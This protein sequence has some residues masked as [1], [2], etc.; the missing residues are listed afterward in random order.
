MDEIIITDELGGEIFRKPNDVS[1]RIMK[2]RMN[3]PYAEM[4]YVG[5]NSS[6]DFIAPKSLGMQYYH[7]DNKEGLY[8]D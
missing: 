1:F 6:K 8:R 4:L 7:Y 3:L 2:Y 5:D